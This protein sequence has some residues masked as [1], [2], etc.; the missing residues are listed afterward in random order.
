MAVKA[1]SCGLFAAL[2]VF[3]IACG[4]DHGPERT[5]A[6]LTNPTASPAP[7]TSSPIPDG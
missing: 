3:A 4:D 5:E 2:I 7:V 6:P 1:I